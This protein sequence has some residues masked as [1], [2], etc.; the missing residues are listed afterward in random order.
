MSSASVSAK[1]N[2]TSRAKFRT[3]RSALNYLKATTNYENLPPAGYDKRNFNLVRMTKILEHLGCPESKMKTV[4]IAG[5]KGKG[6]YCDHGSLYAA[7]LRVQ[8]RLVTHL[9]TCF[10]C[11]RGMTIDGVPPSE[12]EFAKVLSTV[13]IAAERANGCETLKEEIA[14]AAAASPTRRRNIRDANPTFFELITAAAF[15][16]FADN[17]VDVAIIEAGLGGRL[18]S[19][20]VIKPEVCAIT[21]ISYDHMP[22]LGTT[23]A[24]IAEEKAGIIKEG[25]PV[26]SA[27]QRPEVV[28][29]LRSAAANKE[30]PLYFPGENSEFSY[31]FE[32]NRTGWSTHSVVA[33]D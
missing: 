16:W 29:V 6:Q 13:A 30:A 2:G 26:V 11:A 18:D 28:Q 21:S 32:S 7:Q 1:S 15:Q 25:I 27:P 20:N 22:Q 10:R 31:R 5:T 14:N 9:R 3:Y 24:S 33:Y 23:L 19:T 12:K 8:G 17:E 4:H